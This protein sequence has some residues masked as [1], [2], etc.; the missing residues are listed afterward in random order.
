MHHTH[1]YTYIDT[2]THRYIYTFY[3]HVLTLVYLLIQTKQLFT[4]FVHIEAYIFVY[5]QQNAYTYIYTYIYICMYAFSYLYSL[6]YI[7]IYVLD[8]DIPSLS[9]RFGTHRL[10]AQICAQG[11]ASRDAGQWNFQY[12]YWHAC[13]YVM[14]KILRQV[15]PCRSMH[16]FEFMLRSSVL[17][18]LPYGS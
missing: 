15:V 7:Y 10:N 17:Q 2:Y 6:L 5:I 18:G 14:V 12:L 11:R 3:M 4:L 9:Y 16:L 8:H 13:Y 1:I